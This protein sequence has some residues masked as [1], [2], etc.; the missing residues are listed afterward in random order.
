MLCGATL[1]QT[2]K[3]LRYRNKILRKA[4]IRADGKK[5]MKHLNFLNDLGVQSSVEAALNKPAICQPLTAGQ[6][7]SSYRFDL[8][9]VSLRP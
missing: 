9:R 1:H 5:I 6:N 7:A 8:D 3:T 4:S 2:G